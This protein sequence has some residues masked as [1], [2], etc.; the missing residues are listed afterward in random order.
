MAEKRIIRGEANET[1]VALLSFINNNNTTI[2]H[3]QEQF[4]W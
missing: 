4:D 2:N 1:T 3:Q